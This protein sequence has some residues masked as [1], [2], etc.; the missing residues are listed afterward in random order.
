MKV[1][2]FFVLCFIAHEVAP[3]MSG[4][5]FCAAPAKGAKKAT[6]P[7]KGVYYQQLRPKKTDKTSC[8]NFNLIE[9][10]TLIRLNETLVNDKVVLKQSYVANATVNGRWN[11]TLNSEK[12]T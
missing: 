4:L 12:I 6:A 7:K 3:Q 1:S 8:Y 9:A 5:N 10:K 11:L 2:V